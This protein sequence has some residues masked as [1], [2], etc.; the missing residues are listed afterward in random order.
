[1]MGYMRES[2]DGW[3]VAHSDL[4]VS[5]KGEIP[6]LQYWR[7]LRY[8]AAGKGIG[9]TR[10]DR[11]LLHHKNLHRG[12]RCFIMGNG[13]SLNRC[14]L[15]LLKS[16]VTFGVNSIFLNEPTMGFRP[17]YYVVED[18]FVAEDRA[19]Q[20][21]AFDGPTKFFGNYLDYCLGGCPDSI[22]LNVCIDY[23]E[24][25]GFPH[26]SDNAARMLWCGGTVTFICLQL[27]FYMGFQEVILLGF[28]HNYVIPSDAVI[29]NRNDILSVSED[30]NHFHPDYFGKGYRWHDPNVSRME[31]S[32]IRARE[33]Y[34][35]SGRL[36]R[37]ATVGGHLEVFPRVRYE[38][39]F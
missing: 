37:N 15:T 24:Y 18:L 12:Q 13:P 31:R 8:Q 14:D 17:T 3:Y 36:I 11:R 19:P 23:S 34:E 2:I 9:L 20:I 21:K 33:H 5:A 35:A 1:M 4:R 16:E 10:N 29:S 32:F 26:F 28:D 30:P 22:W 25:P 6:S 7:T 39:L 38:E 27:A